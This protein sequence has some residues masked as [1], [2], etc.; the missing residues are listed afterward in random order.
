[1]ALRPTQWLE[2]FLSAYTGTVLVISHDRFF[3][4]RFVNRIFELEHHRL[5]S[6][7]GNYSDFSKIKAER[8]LAEEREY[9]KQTKEIK[10]IEEIIAQQKTFSQE[11]NYRTIRSKQKVI[12]R[13]EKGLVKPKD[14]PASIHFSISAG[15]QSGGDVLMA[16]G[17]CL[18]FDQRELF[19]NVSLDLKRGERAFLL[20]D[21]GS[22]K[23][24][25][26]RVL[27][28]EL[29]SA[30]GYLR[31]GVN[32]SIGYY[33][34]AQ[35]NLD[36]DKTIIEAVVER[37]EDLT[38]TAIRTALGAFLCRGDDI[39]KKISTL[40]GGEKARVAL[41]ILMLSKANLLFLD[42]PTAA[43]D[44]S[45]RQRFWEIVG[46][47][48]DQGVTIVYSSHYIEEVEHTADR[49][50]VLHQGRLL[51][52][53]TPLAMRSEE[54]EKHFTLPLRYQAL[55]A[56]MDGIGQVTVKSDALQVVTGDANRLW[57]R[58]Q[59][60][61][62]SIQEIEV[63]NRSLLD[64]IFENTKEVGREDETHESSRRG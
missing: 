33:D 41:C 8:R 36:P 46:H 49:I 48:K 62:C 34:Q 6:Y 29:E 28:G 60:E 58:L 5:T 16:E 43:M 4:D 25:L 13:I 38:V 55:V 18:R 37:V 14:G 23:T 19:C 12:E 53:T 30:G 27:L 52:D 15:Y 63:T 20:G 57:T 22:G 40:S 2:D 35:V 11:R 1:M 54:V 47:L 44:T 59:E 45:T 39:Q 42:E 17:L 7:C 9:Q 61:G 3:I 51:R 32:V 21:N 26:F 10:R 64:S 56:G 50:L 31:Y 24:S